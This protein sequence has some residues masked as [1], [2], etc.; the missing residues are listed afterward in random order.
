ML[1]WEGKKP[2]VLLLG[3]V[4]LAQAEWNDLG[5]L[6]ELR[7]VNEGTRDRFLIDCKAGVYDG[8][9]A[10]S[11]TYDSTQMTGRFDQELIDVLPS[12]LRF[13][14]HNGAGYDSIDASACATRGISVSNTPGAVDAS[15]ADTT[16]FLIIGALR[17]I[18]IPTTA[19]RAGK[20]RGRMCLTHE[21]EGKTLGILG[22]GGIGTAVARRAVPFGMRIQYHNRSRV[23]ASQNPVGAKYVSFEELLRTSDIISVH[24]P[25]NASTRGMISRD[26]FATMKDGVVLINTARGP[27]VNE[28]ALVEALESGKVWGAG[29]DVHEHEPKIHPELIE[30]E[31]CVLLPHVGTGTLET[32]RKMEVLVCENIKSALEKGHLKTPVLETRKMPTAKG[33]RYNDKMGLRNG[34]GRYDGHLQGGM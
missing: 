14:S 2:I 32:Q 18:H 13:V 16:L 33:V 29:L 9:V 34:V 5:A 25:L 6:A 12:S 31:N 21:P 8:V 19:L 10:I 11:R 27:I 30:N 4:I 1:L 24:L 26:Q 15:T 28:D 17:R 22:M 3:E 23:P 20:W 7:Q